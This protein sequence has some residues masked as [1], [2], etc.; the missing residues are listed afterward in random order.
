MLTAPRWSGSRSG[1]GAGSIIVTYPADAVAAGSGR[2]SRAAARGHPLG[3]APLGH[4]PRLA[5]GTRSAG[6]AASGR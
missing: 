5:D 2:P 6:A 4:A 1:S 3:R